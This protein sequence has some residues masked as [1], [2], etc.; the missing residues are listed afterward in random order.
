MKPHSARVSE[1]IRG[2]LTFTVRD[3]G[4]IDGEPLIALHG[5]PQSA[6]SWTAVAAG[7]ASL[8]WRVVTPDQRGYS[9]GA[10]PHPT[11][12]YRLDRLASDVL[13][14]A[15]T[16]GFETFHLAGHD[17]GGAVAWYLAA[18]HPE[19]IRT[20]TVL[21]TPHPR[22][23]TGSLIRS[24]QLLRSSY[25]GFFRLP[26]LPE[27]LLRARAGA[28]LG[29]LLKS[30][31]MPSPAVETARELMTHRGA[32]RAA[33]AWYR[34]VRPGDLHSI[35][36]ITVPTLFIW[37]TDDGALGP[38]AA[39]HTGEWVNAPYR[40][41][42]LEG[43]SHWILDEVPHQVIPLMDEHFRSVDRGDEA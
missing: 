23:L 16:A 6:D 9:P 32:L 11:A 33:L 18:H 42:L 10:R 43:I 14:L 35:G 20:L 4:P 13:A 27:A 37:S 3:V 36:Q 30:S 12:E 38:H 8:G 1:F 21:S 25:I 15:D 41:E 39:H 29:R 40:F 17:W 26:A 31:G 5:F 28:L 22:A 19:R 7:L 34:A 24:D 2:P